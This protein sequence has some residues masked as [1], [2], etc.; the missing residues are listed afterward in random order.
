MAHKTLQRHLITSVFGLC[1]PCSFA[2]A[3]SIPYAY[4]YPYP[5][6]VYPG[7]AQA[8]T[9]LRAAQLENQRRE[10]E[11]LAIQ[12]ENQRAA[13]ALRAESGGSQEAS[14]LALTPEQQRFKEA[15]MYRRFKWKDFDEVAFAPGVQVTSDMLGLMSESQYAADIAYYLGKHQERSAQIAKMPLR[16]Q[17]AA[18]SDI[19]AKVSA[20]S[21]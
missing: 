2:L 20:S 16:D 9:D 21:H 13:A 10:Q 15:I 12:L 3:Q 4:P 7:S 17:S 6:V 1:L 14:L 5:P 19:E 11:L 18:I 8:V